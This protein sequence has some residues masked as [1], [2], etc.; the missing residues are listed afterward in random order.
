MTA[1]NPEERFA[2]RPKWRRRWRRLPRDISLAQLV[3][4][5][6]AARRRM[7]DTHGMAQSGNADRQERP[8]RTRG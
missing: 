2:I 4:R 3:R 6:D 8:S 1:K 7:R 5:G